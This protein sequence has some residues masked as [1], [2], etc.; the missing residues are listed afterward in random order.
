[1]D[2]FGYG[3]YAGDEPNGS[4]AGM[5]HQLTIPAMEQTADLDIEQLEYSLGCTYDFSDQLS[6]NL[7]AT[8]VDYNDDEP[9]L[10]DMD[11]DALFVNGGITYKF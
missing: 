8:Y 3:V 5:N 7:G 10:Y 4:Y 1:M 6:F 9:Y 2:D 11:G